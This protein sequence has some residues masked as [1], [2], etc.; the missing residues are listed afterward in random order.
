MRQIP[1]LS[2]QLSASELKTRMKTEMG[3]EVSFELKLEEEKAG[4]KDTATLVALISGG[5]SLI[6]V[7]IT[8]IVTILLK[9]REI[10]GEKANSKIVVKGKS[11][12][13]IEFPADASEEEIEK[14]IALA[15]KMDEEDGG[16]KY[17][18]TVH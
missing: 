15:V 1:I 11:G 4:Y 9:I 13:S 12:R 18:A 6:G 5:L 17:I 3:A 10:K 16:L 7:V 2:D 14:Y 8:Q